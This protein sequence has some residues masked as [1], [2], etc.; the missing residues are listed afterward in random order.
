MHTKEAMN[1]PRR[2]SKPEYSQDGSLYRGSLIR[3]LRIQKKLSLSEL[4]NHI[5]CHKAALSKIETN[6]AN[7]STYLLQKI[8]L[9][10]NTT[11]DNLLKAPVHPKLKTNKTT[12]RQTTTAQLD[13]I[14]LLM[15][16]II[17]TLERREGI[18]HDT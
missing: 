10:L 14:E 2:I 15:Y 1:M 5:E 8:A 11:I 17:N 6:G 4:A 16:R 12:Y 3:T 13:R 7:C 9:E 18:H